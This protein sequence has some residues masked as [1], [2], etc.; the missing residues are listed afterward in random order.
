MIGGKINLSKLESVLMTKKGKGD[1]EIEGIFIPIEMNHLFKSEK[2]NVYLDLI[3]FEI[4]NPKYDD[5][6]LL[7]QSLPKEVREAMSDEERKNTAILGGLNVN[8]EGSG[9]SEE[10]QETISEDDDLP[11]E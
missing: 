9:G 2:G 8:L 11:W 10:S 5:T 3:A 7:K 6:H 1:K 4:E